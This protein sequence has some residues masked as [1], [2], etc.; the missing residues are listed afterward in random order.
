MQI[1]KLSDGTWTTSPMYMGF[2]LKEPCPE[3]EHEWETKGSPT[4]LPEGATAPEGM[5]HWSA[6]VC[7]KCS[8]QRMLLSKE[9]K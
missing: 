5:T 1:S 4:V 2:G 3:T 8:Y 7:K 9:A 6:Q